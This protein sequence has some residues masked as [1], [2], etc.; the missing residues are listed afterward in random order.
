MVA[1]LLVADQM[2]VTAKGTETLTPKDTM[3]LAELAGRIPYMPQAKKE[4]GRAHV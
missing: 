3:T 4:I 1:P 2:P